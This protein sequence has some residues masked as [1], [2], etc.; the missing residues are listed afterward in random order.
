[1]NDL[2]V[3]LVKKQY[4]GK[5]YEQIVIETI[6]DGD[7]AY[8]PIQIKDNLAKNLIIKKLKKGDK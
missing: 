2:K 1:M 4:E 5:E 7:I 3:M 6:I 8:I